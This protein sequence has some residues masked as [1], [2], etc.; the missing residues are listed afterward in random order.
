MFPPDCFRQAS[1]R[2]RPAVFYSDRD[3]TKRSREDENTYGR[4]GWH[5]MPTYE[6]NRV[7]KENRMNRSAQRMS[8]VNP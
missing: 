5:I 2:E 7:W 1:L 6:I 4:Q 8:S 3:E